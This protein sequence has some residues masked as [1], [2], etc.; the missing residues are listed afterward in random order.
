MGIQLS[1]KDIFSVLEQMPSSILFK[2]VGTDEIYASAGFTRAFGIQP[3]NFGGI[4]SVKFYDISTKKE[5]D[6]KRDPFYLSEKGSCVSGQFRIQTQSR[7]MICF[8]TSEVIAT[9]FGKCSVLNIVANAAHLIGEF[10]KD[11]AVNK[12]ITFNQLLTNFSSKL[13]NANVSELDSIIDYALAAF[14]EFCDVDRCY[15]FK[16]GDTD[17]YMS[18]THE[19]VAAGVTPYID[20]LQN[21]PTNTMPFF[22]SHISNGIFKVDDVSSIPDS[23]SSEREL[24]QEQRIFSILCVRIMVD[25]PCTDS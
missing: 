14:G 21:I 19:W 22:M 16:F 4:K 11:S 5:V 25:G 8:V 18:N 15:L 12:H 6:T 3:L 23:A 24:F 10:K 13:I 7:T 1:K 17:D 2:F 9:S 20:E